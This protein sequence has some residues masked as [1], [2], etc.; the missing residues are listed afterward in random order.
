MHK[1]LFFLPGL[2]FLNA[3]GSHQQGASETKALVSRAQAEQAFA[4]VEQ[5]DYLPFSYIIDGCY[6]RSLYM[7]LELAAQGIPS[8]EHYVYGQLQ[9]TPEVGWSYHVAP[10]LQVKDSQQEPWILDPA[11]EQEPLSRSQ[12]IKKDFL[13]AKQMEIPINVIAEATT[14]I[15]AGSAYFD[16]TGRAK[17]FETVESPLF[18]ASKDSL[19]R[20]TKLSPKPIDKKLLVADFQQLPSFLTGDIHSACTVMYTYIG[21]EFP[22]AQTD[23]TQAK[24]RADKR[25]RLLSQTTFLVQAMT[26]LGKL[27]SNGLAGKDD[28]PYYAD[29]V[30]EKPASSCQ[31][32][33]ESG[34]LVGM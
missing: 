33:I 3:C 24:Q 4:I 13:A 8:S 23:E 21:E 18:T 34:L 2:F 30:G 28:N 12:W 32:A 22:L 14:Q 20:I 17:A 7:S 19:G 15:R 25:A 26:K 9:P 1:K 31:S 11:F 29:R 10:L 27:T 5:I 6:A 16:L